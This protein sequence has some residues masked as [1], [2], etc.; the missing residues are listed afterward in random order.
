MARV[1]LIQVFLGQLILLAAGLALLFSCSQNSTPGNVTICLSGSCKG[2][3][4]LSTRGSSSVAK[5]AEPEPEGSPGSGVTPN[6]DVNPNPVTPIPTPT[7]TAT[8]VPPLEARQ[9]LLKLKENCHGCHGLAKDKVS[10]WATPPEFERKTDA[11]I[12]A[13]KESLAEKGE[14]FDEN[15]DSFVSFETHIASDANLNK[16]LERM[17]VDQLSP[18]VFKAIENGLLGNESSTPKAMRPHMDEGARAAFLA[19][20]DG[21]TPDIK[22]KTASAMPM[23]HAEAQSWC[24]G[25]HS[26]GGRGSKVWAKANGD[27]ADWTEFAAQIKSSVE[28]KRMPPPKPSAKEK[29]EWLGVLAFFQKRLPNVVADAREKYHGDKL[30]LGLPVNLNF[31]CKTPK[32]SRQFLNVLTMDALNR[33]PTADELKLVDDKPV[34]EA[35]REQL[36]EKIS[37]DW[38]TEFLN[39]GLK[40]FAE[41]VSLSDKIR[42]SLIIDDPLLR[43]DIA[44]EFYHYLKN[45]VEVSYQEILTSDQVYATKNTA[46]FYGEDCKKA[47]SAADAGQFI[48]CKMDS[49]RKGFFTTLGFL[50]GRSSS[51]FQENNNYGRVAAM[52]EVLQ[53]EWLRPNTNG[54]KGETIKPLPSCIVSA[55]TRVLIQGDSY[56]PRGTITVPASGNFCQGCHIHRNLAA[57]SIVFRP[58]GPIGELVTPKSIENLLIKSG[59]LSNHEQILRNFI[60]DSFSNK[61]GLL[62]S[63]SNVEGFNVGTISDFLNIGKNIG[64][65]KGCIV[66][67]EGNNIK[68]VTS[69]S[70]LADHMLSDEKVLPRGLARIIPRALSN[71]N[72]TNLEI[73]KTVTDSWSESKGNLTAAI[74]A[75]F[76]SDTYACDFGAEGDE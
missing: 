75:Y 10:F 66:D 7:P 22:E 67:G 54:E 51:M 27:L 70:D 33:V 14:T 24:V 37:G 65:E 40:K 19:F 3:A 46:P 58:F 45:E 73:I 52:S 56:A 76:A 41:K 25:C 44:L 5:D 62:Q 29:E 18:A 35:L 28:A 17:T 8:P 38:K 50:A 74:H 31:K 34:S 43:N 47:T 30:E 2:D 1:R 15:S 20:I 49:S 72:S 6:P 23:S 48:K 60:N 57:G 55:D 4:N 12:K 21:L 11:E 71:L 9:V 63:S 36:V 61:W 39:A 26:P 64:Q 69:V 42:N 32:S 16:I 59:T 13:L 53:G 68:D